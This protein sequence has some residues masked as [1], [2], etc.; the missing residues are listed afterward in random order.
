MRSLVQWRRGLVA[1]WGLFLVA[2]LAACGGSGGDGGGSTVPPAVTCAAGALPSGAADTTLTVAGWAGRDH[3]L[4][5]PATYQCGQPIAVLI[6]FHGGGGNKNNMRSATCPGGDAA[7]AA[8]LHSQALAAGMA[9]VFPNGTANAQGL[10]TWNAGGGQ[11]GY[12][13]VSAGACA[14]NI[15]DVAYVRALLAGLGSRI[16]VDAKRVFASGFSNG[17]ALTQRLACEA[18]DVFAAVAPVSGQNQFALAGC[19]PARPVA[20]LDIHGTLDSCWPY[21]GGPGGCIETGLYVSVATTLEGWRSRNGCASPAEQMTLPSFVGVNDG[22]SVVQYRWAGCAAGG[23]VEH[24]Q[25][26]GGGHSWPRGHDAVNG[27]A[28]TG[29]LS[30]QL[31]A[32]RAIVTFLAANGRP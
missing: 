14:A 7:S 10:R 19:T 9:V 11:G 3:D 22:T 1:V 28:Q 6:V 8:C 30:Q 21:A 2:A 4:L 32:S 13:C 17:A 27:I 5:L 31:D 15:N 23:P 26:L 29:V 24:L 12:I 20:V 16:T 18:A 25:V